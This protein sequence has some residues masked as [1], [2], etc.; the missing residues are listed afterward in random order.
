MI[1]FTRSLGE[2]GEKIAA[3][4]GNTELLELHKIAFLCSRKIPASV[5]LKCYD[6]AIAQ[7]KRGNC[8][9]SGFHSTIEK[10]VFHYLLQGT[11]PVILALA[12]GMKKKSNRD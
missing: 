2:R 10:D 1:N 5:V 4:L 11:Q 8:I 9:I 7:R 12:R 3:A 6:W